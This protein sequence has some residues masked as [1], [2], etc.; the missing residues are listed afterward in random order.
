M[1]QGIDDNPEGQE[2]AKEGRR[3]MRAPHYQGYPSQY[4]TSITCRV[5]GLPP[6]ARPKKLTF[7]LGQSVPHVQNNATT[8]CTTVSFDMKGPIVAAG[9]R[10]MDFVMLLFGYFLSRRFYF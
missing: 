5:S 7:D 6:K 3:R 9:V 4:N 10:V 2:S 1:R 8:R